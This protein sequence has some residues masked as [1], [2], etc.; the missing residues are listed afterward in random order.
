MAS[1]THP[2]P[3]DEHM[4]VIS[5]MSLDVSD[6]LLLSWL[7]GSRHVILGRHSWLSHIIA[8]GLSMR[9]ATVSIPIASSCSAESAPPRV[10]KGCAAPIMDVM[11]ST[12]LASSSS[13]MPYRQQEPSRRL[14]LTAWQAGPADSMLVMHVWLVEQNGAL[15]SLKSET[16]WGSMSPVVKDSSR[17]PLELRASNRAM[18]HVSGS[19]S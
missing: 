18:P 10:S 2:S 14:V 3:M 15:F 7:G 5:S 11:A 9:S 6:M 19:A 12:Q 17:R 1:R 8:S 13:T 4:S 16:A